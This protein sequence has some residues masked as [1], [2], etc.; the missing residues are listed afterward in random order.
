MN[1]TRPRDGKLVFVASLYSRYSQLFMSLDP[2]TVSRLKILPN[3]SVIAFRYWLVKS[4]LVSS[5][6]SCK[7]QDIFMKG[8]NYRDDQDTRCT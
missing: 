4:I 5:K 3:N 6:V 2:V 1:L 7:F 8:N